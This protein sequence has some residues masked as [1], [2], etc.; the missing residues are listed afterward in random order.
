MT[1]ADCPG[2]QNN[3]Q[4]VLQNGCY[5]FILNRIK[6][7]S[8]MFTLKGVI[9]LKKKTLMELNTFSLHNLDLI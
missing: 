7:T 9:L 6:S 2:N 5:V 8:N 3:E 4:K 1:W